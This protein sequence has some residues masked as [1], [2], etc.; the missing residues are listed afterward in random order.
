ML[1]TGFVDSREISHG[2]LALHHR[3]VSLGK[4]A[5]RLIVLCRRDQA[6]IDFVSRQLPLSVWALQE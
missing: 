3:F 2:C 1:L 6:V 5:V 4:E